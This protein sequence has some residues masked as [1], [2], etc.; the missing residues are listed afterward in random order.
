MYI[1][2]YKVKDLDIIEQTA[3]NHIKVFLKNNLSFHINT[4]TVL[5]STVFTFFSIHSLGHPLLK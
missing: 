4:Y 3:I 1:N 5:I 2:I